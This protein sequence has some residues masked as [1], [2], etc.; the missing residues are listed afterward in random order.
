MSAFSYYDRWFATKQF[1][2]AEAT[3]T[4]SAVLLFM[5]FHGPF[6]HLMQ[7]DVFNEDGSGDH[8]E[9]IPYGGPNPSVDEIDPFF[10]SL[11]AQYAIQ[12]PTEF[13]D[14]A[15]AYLSHVNEAFE[16]TINL[17]ETDDQQEF[18]TANAITIFYFPE[19]APGKGDFL[20]LSN[21]ATGLYAA[22][23]VTTLRE[24]TIRVIDNSL[25][26]LDY[27]DPEIISQAQDL[28]LRVNNIQAAMPVNLIGS[29]NV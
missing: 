14:N 22:G 2:L 6:P 21:D 1:T 13:R 4:T 27:E 20:S 17:G 24:T 9:L 7:I 28:M 29:S 25:Y 23:D 3:D 15:K 19:Y 11:E 8:H 5:A 12:V 18:D 26:N 16:V 10:D